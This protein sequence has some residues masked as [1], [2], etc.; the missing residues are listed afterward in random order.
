MLLARHSTTPY[1]SPFL[2]RF[3]KTM[4]GKKI[5]E[6]AER[7]KNCI[8][9]DDMPLL[10]HTHTHTHTYIGFGMRVRAKRGSAWGG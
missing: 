2:F 5:G 4:R 3:V 8:R 7:Q 1:F 9:R 10:T 6:K